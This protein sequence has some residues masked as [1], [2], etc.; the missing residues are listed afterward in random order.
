MQEEQ[1]RFHEAQVREQEAAA[2]ATQAATRAELAKD[3]AKTAEQLHT[4]RVN[5]AV[6]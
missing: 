1:N 4:A 5:E 3:S 6:N 2:A